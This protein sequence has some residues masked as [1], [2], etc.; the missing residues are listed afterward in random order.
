MT[1]RVIINGVKGKMGR[2]LE[3]AI[4]EQ[5][6]FQ[7]VAGCDAKDDLKQ[8]IKNTKADVVVDFTTPQSVFQNAKTIIESGARPIIGTTGLSE[9]HIQTLSQHCEERKLGGIIAPNFSLSAVLMMKYAQDAAHYFSDVEIIEMHHPQKIDK[10]SGTATKT[11][12]MMQQAFKESRDIPIHSVRLPG[13][14][15]HQMVIF[16]GIGETLT[17]Q[18]DGM[19]RNAMMP[20]VFLACQKVMDLDHLIYG[21]EHL[22]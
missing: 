5:Q 2:V 8:T 3:H 18:H 13:L 10:P 22:L 9:Q 21:L 19:D 11:A 7:L 12:Q 4:A 17:I 20:G 14:F 15:S 6:D 1:I 16:G